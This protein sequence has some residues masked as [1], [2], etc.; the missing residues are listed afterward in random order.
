[1]VQYAAEELQYHVRK[2][3]GAELHIVPETD[4]DAG[5][6]HRIYLGQCRAT[7]AAGIE[8]EPEPP[9]A[10]IYATRWR[11][12]HVL[13]TVGNNLFMTGHDSD[14]PVGSRFQMT[15]HGTL[16]AVYDFLENQMGVRWL[17]PGDLGEVIPARKDVVVG[18]LDVSARER[19]AEC[20]MGTGTFRYGKDRWQSQECFQAY[21]AAVVKWLL[22]H[23]MNVCNAITYSYGHY[24][25][26]NG[27]YTE[28]FLQKRPD[29][30]QLL[31]DGTRGYIPGCHGHAISMCVSTP[32]LHAQ[33]IRDWQGYRKKYELVRRGG[34][35]MGGLG[36]MLNA[37]E[38][39]TCASCTCEA[40]RAWDAPDPRFK[41]HDY[42]NGSRY[43]TEPG[44]EARYQAARPDDDGDPA[45]EL[46][47]RYA[48]LYLTLQKKAEKVDPGV[49]VTG[50]A[51]SNYTEPPAQVKLND[52]IV[53]LMVPWPY[54]PW[55]QH[56]IETMKAKWE[57]WYASG[58]RLKLRPNTLH[59]GHNYPIFLAR[60]MG[61]MFA[62]HVEHSAV[63]TAFDS[64]TG[65]WGSKGPDYYVLTRMH[66]HP[67]WP[68][69]K[70]L[71]EYYAGFGKAAEA[72]R[73]YFEYWEQV[74]ET[75]TKAP[76]AGV[77]ASLQ[78]EAEGG[79]WLS[80]RTTAITN[81]A[82][83]FTPEVMAAG[84]GLIQDAQQA[85]AGAPAA[86]QR[87]AFLEKG[88]RHAEL[89]LAVA[90]T[91][92]A[93]TADPTDPGAYRAYADA[94]GRLMAFRRDVVEPE[95]IA[96]TGYLGYN[97]RRKELAWNHRLTAED[98]ASLASQWQTYFANRAYGQDRE[99]G[100]FEEATAAY[101][102]AEGWRF[103]PDP[104]NIG[105]GENWQAEGLDDAGWA[106][107][108]VDS[109]WKDQPWGATWRERHGGKDYQGIGWYRLYFSV[110][111]GMQPETHRIHLFFG[112]VD[113]AATVWL[114][115]KPVGEKKFSGN[116]W[117]EPFDLDVTDAIRRDR[118]NTLA[119]RVDY[120]KGAGGIWKPVWLAPA[121]HH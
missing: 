120:V 20:E 102:L 98:G 115:G 93:Q 37:C 12:K 34:K 51:Y 14:G 90:R 11:V 25:H 67:D 24:F 58:A 105:A 59:T 35:V 57:G 47:D 22:R 15:R 106:A 88:L 80:G 62:H 117:Q 46:S 60:K 39:D 3:S 13:R 121:Q 76:P 50:Y 6:P 52:R 95:M 28:R 18:E 118:P 92:A 82:L 119:V 32:D 63:A 49:V 33:M 70:V 75:V 68:V 87:V 55:T 85:A 113:A 61:E 29:F 48:R 8:L 9:P 66:T 21:E 116:S 69:Q 1:V 27:K 81:G 44:P 97:E 111:E 108:G 42:W 83:I 56:D 112:A 10:E 73:H 74:S 91:H 54:F 103:R 94:M 53:I 104:D 2:A 36:W 43:I 45:P 77:R 71:D 89:T 64:L 86:E 72:V 5:V 78:G 40:C 31:P 100:Q 114:N 19:F 17:W 96:D 38:N 84:R 16:F 79:G 23:R 7:Q 110:P 30:F 107:I 109:H 4:A 26:S 99:F 41:S 101:R 65:Q